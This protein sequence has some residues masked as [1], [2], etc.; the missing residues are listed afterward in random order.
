MRLSLS[1]SLYIYIYVNYAASL[2]GQVLAHRL[3]LLDRAAQ[4]GDILL[5][6]KTNI[7]VVCLCVLIVLC[8]CAGRRYPACVLLCLVMLLACLCVLCLCMFISYVSSFAC[9]QYPPLMLL[10]PSLCSV[11][12]NVIM[13]TYVYYV[14][15]LY[16]SGQ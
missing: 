16:C 13:F 3:D 8:C 1:L 12:F 15:F 5:L 14:V 6:S 10:Y 9:R 4:V 2:G 7:L 11:M